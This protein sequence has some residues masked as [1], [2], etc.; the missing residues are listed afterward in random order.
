MS[1]FYA[2][3]I[4]PGDVIH[5]PFEG[6][7]YE[8][9]FVFGNKNFKDHMT[10]T[11]RSIRD[12]FE[13]VCASFVTL[14]ID[15]E[16]THCETLADVV[17]ALFPLRDGRLYS[18]DELQQWEAFLLQLSNV[19]DKDILPLLA[20]FLSYV[21]NRKYKYGIIRGS[22]QSD[23]NNVIYPAEY[24]N[25]FLQTF[26][27]EYFNE[28]SE[29]EIHEGNGIPTSPEEIQG[30]HVYCTSLGVNTIVE[31]LKQYIDFHEGDTLILWEFECYEHIPKYKLLNSVVQSTTVFTS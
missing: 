21:F 30:F 28:G 12:R 6:G 25:D 20:D 13:E 8:D 5:D 26:S 19:R 22:S 10:E 2:Y 14:Y 23:W 4:P 17:N 1:A 3:Q 29:W 9:V 18:H 11:F 24:G 16:S 31:E 15:G 27:V 7:C